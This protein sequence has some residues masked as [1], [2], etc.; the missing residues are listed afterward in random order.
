MPIGDSLRKLRF[1]VGNEG[2][3]PA[4]RDLTRCG[5]ACAQKL[6]LLQAARCVVLSFPQ[7]L[8]G[9]AIARWVAAAQAD[10]ES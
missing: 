10:A 6:T 4:D 1:P 2:A 8:D 7:L 5:V 9:P 3:C